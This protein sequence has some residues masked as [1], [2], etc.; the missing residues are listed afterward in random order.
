MLS[1][2]RRICHV[3]RRRRSTCSG[4]PPASRLARRACPGSGR[5]GAAVQP[6]GDRRCSRVRRLR[7]R[8]ADRA[9][10]GADGT[11]R[12]SGDRRRR[13]VEKM[14]RDRDR[15]G[16][17]IGIRSVEPRDRPGA[18]CRTPGDRAG[19]AACRSRDRVGRCRGRRVEADEA[20]SGASSPTAGSI[21]RHRRSAGV[22]QRGDSLRADKILLV[23][24]LGRSS[25]KSTAAAVQALD[26]CAEKMMGLVITPRRRRIREG[27]SS[28]APGPP[29][30]F[31]AAPS[32]S[33]LMPS[34]PRRCPRA[35]H[36]LA[37]LP[38]LPVG[39]PR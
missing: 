39:P 1:P 31:G 23:V 28:V 37:R 25:R 34:V 21:G 10:P 17:G 9:C 16:I 20:A 27:L 32:G 13:I 26:H 22:V 19:G 11:R 18:P 5:G 35:G 24:G 33:P 14:S 15:D 38:P 6:A 2:W 8:A 29:A 12:G 30:T 7:G 4:W 36:V 3:C